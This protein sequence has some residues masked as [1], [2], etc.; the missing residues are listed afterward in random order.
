MA[1]KT[2][3]TTADGFEAQFG[4]NH[5]A[6][7]LLF[8]E[9]KPLLLAST[10]PAFSSRV[11]CLSS[12]G[13]RTHGIYFDDY[14]L[15]K[16]GNYSPWGSYGQS[17]TANIYMANEI[18][19]RYGTKGLH[20]ISLHPGGI[21]TGLQEHVSD[22]MKAMWSR[23]DVQ[24]QFKSVEQGSATTVYAALSKEYANRGGCYL[25]DCDETAEVSGSGPLSLG[26]A[27]HAFDEEGEKKLWVDS[28]K[29]VGVSDQ[30]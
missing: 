16:E 22:D 10:T 20:G 26:H 13:H 9:L 24:K 15:E 19:R 25:E 8:Q 5:L 29:M 28:C 23:P 1:L 14:K 21:A 12:S 17:K 30:D 2:R 18:E 6:H 27:K 4:T 7:F 11:I 3:E